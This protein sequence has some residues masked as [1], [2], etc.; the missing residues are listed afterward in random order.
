MKLFS[1]HKVRH[2]F[3]GRVPSLHHEHTS[4]KWWVL[5]NV[6]IGTF[7]AVLDA[8]VVNVAL[9][10]IMATYGVS[11]DKIE[12]VITAYL[13]VFAI[14]LPT[15]GW[16]ADHFGYKRTYF[17]AL[18]LFT[19]GSFL[20][21]LA[22]DE[23]VLIVFRIIQAMGAGFLMP[24]GMAIV[25]REFPLEQRGIALG[26]WSIAAAASVSLGPLIGG[27]LVDNIGWNAIFDVNVPVGI[28]GL[29]ATLVI[30][31]EYKSDKAR[32][33][34]ILGFISVSLFLG[35]LLLALSDGNAAWNTGGWTSPF[36]VTCFFISAISLIV[37]LVTE[38]SVMHPLIELRL[39]KNV[40]FGITNGIL[41]IFG[42]GM[43]GSTF[44]LPLYLQNSLG[45]TAL[46]AGAVF[47]PVGILQAIMAPISGYVSDR[48]NPKIPAAIGIVL[49]AIS[50]YLNGSLSLYSEQHDIMLPLIIRGFAMGMLFTPLSTIALSE[51][52][53]HKIAQASGQFNVI[54]QLGGSFGV[55]IMGTLLTRRIFYHST[56]YGQVIDQYSATFRQISSR[57]TGFAMHV[58]GGTQGLAVQKA[59]ALLVSHVMQQSFV[60]AIDDDF[61]VAAAITILGLVP[62]FILRTHKRPPK[63][64][65][66]AL[67]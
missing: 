5:L 31:R 54:R 63:T 50:L 47:L 7:M 56:E 15:S 8:T 23:D 26:F 65:Q 27:Y 37:F 40:N 64:K 14:M 16:V 18:F 66:G 43:F 52:P 10:K 42:L 11:L 59:K 1:T 4:Y 6:M 38:L 20:C 3:V 28:F 2:T 61:I 57:L 35:A 49:L 44:L 30:Q 29:F 13:L 51:I 24:V 62:I 21:G 25:T 22:W 67:E 55:A 9:P 45:Y 60:R 39:M 34:D 33:F 48:I 58:S 12:W 53:R 36:I 46:Q 41:F 32:S 19:F 17:F